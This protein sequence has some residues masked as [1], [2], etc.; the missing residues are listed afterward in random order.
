MLSRYHFNGLHEE[1]AI[2]LSKIGHHDEALKEYVHKL[3]DFGMAED[4]C[5][6]HYDHEN[7]EARDVYLSLLK[8]YMTPPGP[9][10][11]NQEELHNN[12]YQLLNKYYKKIDTVKAL[13]VLQEMTSLSMLYPYFGKVFRD[14]N[15]EKRNNQVQTN[16]QKCETMKVK[17]EYLK[18]RSRV[19]K[20]TDE[21]LCAVCNKRLI[22]VAFALYPTTLT[23]EPVTVHYLCYKNQ[24]DKNVCP[25]TGER[26]GEITI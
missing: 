26:F 2:L 25:A 5:K 24:K 17:S 9:E 18:L 16:L 23:D 6:Q 12:A 19:V 3:H 1:R 15:K 10:A 4:Y 7:E 13:E 8:V 21:T 11:P 22:D 14:I 20:V